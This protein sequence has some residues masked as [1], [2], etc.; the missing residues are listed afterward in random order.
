MGSQMGR[1]LVC[2]RDLQMEWLRDWPTVQ[3]KEIHWE[4]QK[5]QQ[6]G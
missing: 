5:V 2:Q 4:R 3:W 6:R 1:H